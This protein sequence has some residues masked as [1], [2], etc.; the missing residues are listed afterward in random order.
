[1][2]KATKAVQ[3]VQAVPAVTSSTKG[4]AN[5][6]VLS[7]GFVYI[8]VVHMQQCEFGKT[9]VVITTARNLRVYGAT[10]GLGQLADG[11]QKDTVSDVIEDQGVVFAPFEKLEHLIP[12]NA[13]AW[14]LTED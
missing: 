13:A 2:A 10:K 9:W 3:A 7:S 11:P 12:C 6:V 5:I 8:G 14:G 1:M 4:K